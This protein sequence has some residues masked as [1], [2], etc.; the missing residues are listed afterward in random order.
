M[1]AIRIALPLLM[2]VFLAGGVMASEPERYDLAALRGTQIAS[3][4]GDLNG[5]TLSDLVIAAQPTDS[6]RVLAIYFRCVTG[7]YQCIG[8]YEQL[9]PPPDPEGNIQDEISLEITKRRVLKVK[10][11]QFASAGSWGVTN[12]A[13]LFRYQGLGFYRIGSERECF[14]RNT[15]EIT[16]VSRNYLTHKEKRVTSNEFDRDIPRHETWSGIPKAP[17]QHIADCHLGD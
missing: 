3:A 4:D 15:G 16:H 5:D 1:K 9:L 6:A 13:D 17:L 14:M 7:V 11:H 12:D 2:T 10:L 8:Q